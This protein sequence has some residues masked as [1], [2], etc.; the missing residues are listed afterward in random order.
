MKQSMCAN[1]IVLYFWKDYASLDKCP[2]C[3]ESR[4]NLNDRKGKQIPQKVLRY[5]PLKERLQRLF[6]SKHTI[7]DMRCHKDKRCETE[8]ILRYP[9]DAK[10]WKHFNELVSL[11]CFRRLKCQIS[12][13]KYEHIIQHVASYSHSIQLASLEVYKS[14]IHFSIFTHPWFKVSWYRTGLW[15]QNGREK[16]ESDGIRRKNFC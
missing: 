2:H 9:A 10:S 12:I 16:R 13:W 14:I 7:E 1:L 6:I 15:D 8:G 3:G 11:F 5:F 4:Y